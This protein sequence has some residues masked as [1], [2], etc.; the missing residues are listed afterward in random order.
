MHASKRGGPSS[1]RGQARAD[2]TKMHDTAVRRAVDLTPQTRSRGGVESS[3][4]TFVAPNARSRRGHIRALRSPSPSVDH[5]ITEPRVWAPHEARS[6]Y[7]FPLPHPPSAPPDVSLPHCLRF[8]PAQPKPPK[9]CRCTSGS[10][11]RHRPSGSP[12]VLGPRGKTGRGG[13]Q[14]GRRRRRCEGRRGM[15]GND[16]KVNS[17]IAPRHRSPSAVVRRGDASLIEAMR[18]PCEWRRPHGSIAER[19]ESI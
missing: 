15:R 7:P 2:R 3:P 10:A 12:G 1:E 6:G 17:E 18:R 4:S 5:F 19:V 13:A 9:R 16:R 8:S 11:R 14:V